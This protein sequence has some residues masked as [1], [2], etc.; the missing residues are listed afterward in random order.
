MLVAGNQA[1]DL[2]SKRRAENKLIF[3]ITNRNQWIDG[4]IDQ[5]SLRVQSSKTRRQILL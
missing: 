1:A 2:S 3:R 5:L 4:W